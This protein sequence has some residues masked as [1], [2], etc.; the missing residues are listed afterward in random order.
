[1]AHVAAEHRRGLRPSGDPDSAEA[2]LQESSGSLA[3]PPRTS[4]NPSKKGTEMALLNLGD[5]EA[6][7]QHDRLALSYYQQV[8]DSRPESP[9]WVIT[10]LAGMAAA[11]ERL[12]E[13]QQA[14]DLLRE[15]M[16]LSEKAGSGLQ[17]ARLLC[18]LGVNQE[19]LGQLEDALASQER[20][21]ALVH[22]T[23]GN[24]DYEWQIESRLGH[25]QRISFEHY[26]RSIEGSSAF[27]RAP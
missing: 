12:G 7:R 17:Y 1:M 21:L 4:S 9:L 8:H 23:G 26:R 13:P 16:L 19:S 20:A 15:A 18:H 6:A 24:P 10:A 11:H 14:I 25:V 2:P 27:A 22:R 5:L 3:G